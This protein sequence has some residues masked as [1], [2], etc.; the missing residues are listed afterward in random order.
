MSTSPTAINVSSQAANSPV[1]R[2]VLAAPVGAQPSTLSV[3]VPVP[4]ARLGSGDLQIS[5]IAPQFLQT[6]SDTLGNFGEGTDGFDVIMATPLLSFDGDVSA[7]ASLDQNL[8]DADFVTDEILADTLTPVSNDMIAFTQS[9]DN[10]FNALNVAVSP[11][12]PQPPPPPPPPV[13]TPGQPPP[14]V[15]TPAGGGGGFCTDGIDPLTGDTVFSECGVDNPGPGIR[16][17]E[18]P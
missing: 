17:P 18:L 1:A 16:R 5:P 14:P 3:A 8:L 6:T 2:G 9:G 7:M 4:L 15:P 11:V 13:P 10:L 12:D